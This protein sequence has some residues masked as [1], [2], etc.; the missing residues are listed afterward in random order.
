MEKKQIIECEVHEC[1]FCDVECDLCKLE[2]IKVCNC[3][4]SGL[5]ENTMC[6][7]Y[8]EGKDK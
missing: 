5:K 4:G 2:I 6:D 8:K 7:S 1:K 3:Y